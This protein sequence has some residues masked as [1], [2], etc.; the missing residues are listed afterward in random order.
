[1]FIFPAGSRQAA[2]GAH[3]YETSLLESWLLQK[4]TCLISILNDFPVPIY[5]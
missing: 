2:R 3:I 5:I 4:K 1:M